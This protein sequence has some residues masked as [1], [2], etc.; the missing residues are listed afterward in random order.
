MI[1]QFTDAY[2]RHSAS[3][4]QRTMTWFLDIF[5]LMAPWY[6]TVVCVRKHFRLHVHVGRQR[7]LWTGE[8]L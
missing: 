8:G 5:P 1:A 7:S 6:N 4:S 3:M 2:M